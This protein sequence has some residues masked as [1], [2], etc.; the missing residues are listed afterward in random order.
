MT[1]RF[2]LTGLD[3]EMPLMLAMPVLPKRV[4]DP[5]RFDDPTL[6]LPIGTGPYVVAVVQ[7]GRE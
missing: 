3:S 4:T 2:D 5:E 1:V 6:K 7:P